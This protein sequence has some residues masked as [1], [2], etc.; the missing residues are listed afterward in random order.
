MAWLARGV[1]ITLLCDLVPETGP[2]SDGIN[3]VERPADD[4]I[5]LEHCRP[6]AIERTWRAM[7]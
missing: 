6:R 2:D 1:P 4:P 7:A 3:S 5:W